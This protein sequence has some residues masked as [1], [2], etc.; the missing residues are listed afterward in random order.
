MS[1]RRGSWHPAQESD[2]IVYAICNRFLEQLGQHCSGNA[3]DQKDRRRG[4]AAAVA[5]WARKHL[6][7]EDLTRE[8]IYPLF[9]E[10]VRR[11]YLLLCP[12]RESHLASEIRKA[13]GLE[14]FPEDSIQVVNVRGPEAARN[15]SAVAADLTFQL[16]HRLRG[17]KEKVHVGLGAGYSSMM[18]ARRLAQRVYSDLQ[19]PPLVLHAISAGGFFIDQP[20]K[21]PVTYFGYFSEVITPVEY[22][23]LF[24]EPLVSRQEYDRVRQ[25]P[26]V[27]HSFER[28]KEIDIVIT[29]FAAAQDEHGMLGQFLKALQQEGTITQAEI[30]TMVRAGWVGD[31]QFRPYSASGPILEECPVQVVTLFEIEELVALA[32]QPNKYVVL[33]AGPCSECQRL[34]TDALRPLLTNPRLRLWTHLVMDLA[35]AYD[36]LRSL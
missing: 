26:S 14:S 8:R 4:A 22:V 33:I 21:A 34:K 11:Q 20:Y 13:F 6:G 30:D 29:S 1:P 9:W 24:S 2:E 19:C 28:A 35:T 32:Q 12:P 16:I 15:V 10:A 23:G 31:V 5:A 27:R 36:L 25:N 18:V 3:K 7:R 17:K